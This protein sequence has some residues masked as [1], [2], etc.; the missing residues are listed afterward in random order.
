MCYFFVNVEEIIKGF[1]RLVYWLM[2][3]RFFLI[4]SGFIYGGFRGHLFVITSFPDPAINEGVSL[5]YL[6][7]ILLYGFFGGCIGEALY[8]F[9]VRDNL[10]R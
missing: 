5:F 2:T 9:V 3:N 4:I 1:A 7:M 10:D 8:R 6:E